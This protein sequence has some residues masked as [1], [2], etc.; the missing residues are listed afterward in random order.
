ML[1]PV[2]EF[3]EAMV[4]GIACLYLALAYIVKW[5]HLSCGCSVAL[6]R[7]TKFDAYYAICQTHLSESSGGG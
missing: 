3:L 4:V 5:T 6:V 1:V 7:G 2:M